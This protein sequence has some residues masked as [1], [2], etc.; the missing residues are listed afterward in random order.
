M[1]CAL[2]HTPILMLI[3]STI[4]HDISGDFHCTYTVR[5]LDYKYILPS[6]SFSLRCLSARSAQDSAI[7]TLA[8]SIW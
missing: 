8:H 3:L 2:V 4:S 5:R 7:L 1:E 6:C